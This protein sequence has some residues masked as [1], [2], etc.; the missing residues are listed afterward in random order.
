MSSGFRTLTRRSGWADKDVG[1]AA[2]NTDLATWTVTRSREGR[3]Q[4]AM[5]K[6]PSH[7]HDDWGVWDLSPVPMPIRSRLYS[8]K[9][10]GVGSAGV[11]SLTSYLARLAAAHCVFPATLIEQIMLPR[12]G[13][14]FFRKRD[15]RGSHLVNATGVPASVTY[16]CLESLTARSDLRMLTLVTWSNVI[17]ILGLLRNTKAWCP[18][19]YEEWAR[20]DTVIYEPLLWA[21]KAVTVCVRHQGCLREVCPYHDCAKSQP[22]LG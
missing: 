8:L 17:G 9:P 1:V 16:Q 22:P 15:G 14:R 18:G 2:F 13:V 20:A 21:F 12:L 7:W 6:A 19:C 10:M 3:N 5:H 11:E 4:E